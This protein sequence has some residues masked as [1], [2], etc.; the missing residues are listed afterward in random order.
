MTKKFITYSNETDAN[1]WKSNLDTLFGC[2]ILKPNGYRMNSSIDITKSAV[3]NEWGGF[4]IRPTNSIT[5]E[6]IESQRVAGYTEYASKPS[7]W[8]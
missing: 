3:A 7:D 4:E 1:S 2:P 8:D 5:Q 6:Q